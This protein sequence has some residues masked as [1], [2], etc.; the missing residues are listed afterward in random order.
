M[1][2]R[3]DDETDTGVINKIL[4]HQ[5]TQHALAFLNGRSGDDGNGSS[6]GTRRNLSNATHKRK[7]SQRNLSSRWVADID[8]RQN[9]DGSAPLDHTASKALADYLMRGVPSHYREHIGSVM[10]NNQV[11][12]S[13]EGTH[14]TA[15]ARLAYLVR[16]RRDDYLISTDTNAKLNNNGLTS[17]NNRSLIAS[18][19][20]TSSSTSA[21]S[22]PL[23]ERH[24]GSLLSWFVPSETVVCSTKPLLIDLAGEQGILNK[25][26][27]T[28]ISGTLP[29]MQSTIDDVVKENVMSAVTHPSYRIWAKSKVVT[30]T[31]SY[32]QYA[33]DVRDQKQCGLSSFQEQSTI[34][35]KGKG[36]Q[37][38]GN[39]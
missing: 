25:P 36:P 22:K 39:I 1:K 35:E 19:Q 38:Y 33:G 21:D 5:V 24:L 20:H 34:L 26:L 17:M 2:K 27:T 18:K 3:N 30:L 8:G 28:I 15:F 32:Q 31:N 16:C 4:V 14:T 29:M 7:Q 6:K 11:H 10:H 12:Q 9:S 13:N 37:A 23:G